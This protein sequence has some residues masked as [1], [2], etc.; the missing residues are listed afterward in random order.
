MN[1]SDIGPEMS[2]RVQWECRDCHR[3][4]TDS[5]EFS[6]AGVKAAAQAV[7]PAEMKYPRKFVPD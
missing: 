2:P 4:T 7:R 1:L 5:T 6:T 3:L